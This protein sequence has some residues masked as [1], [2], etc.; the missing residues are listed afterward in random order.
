MMALRKLRRDQIG[1][2]QFI[3]AI[4]KDEVSPC[5]IS[6]KPGIASFEFSKKEISEFAC[7]QLRAH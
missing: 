2:V 3:E 6:T 7:G 4:L 5:G 1:M